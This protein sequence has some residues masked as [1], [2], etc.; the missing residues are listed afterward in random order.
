G[1]DDLPHLAHHCAGTTGTATEELHPV[2][3]CSLD[4]PVCLGHA[5]SHGLFDNDV[6]ATLGGQNDVGGV[7]CVGRGDPDDID[8]WV[9]AQRLNG[10]VGLGVVLLPERLQR[11]RVDI[12]SSDQAYLRHGH[13]GRYDHGGGQAQTDHANVQGALWCRHGSMLR[14]FL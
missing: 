13:H 9:I 1:H 11:S 12:G 3:V 10:R 6:L 7:E 5:D 8:V 14:W 4:H 2:P